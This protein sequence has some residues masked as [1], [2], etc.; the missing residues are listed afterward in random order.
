LD[1]INEPIAF[2]TDTNDVAL[3]SL[4]WADIFGCHITSVWLRRLTLQRQATVACRL[5][6]LSEDE[7]LSGCDLGFL[8]AGGVE[9]VVP[10]VV[11]SV[12]LDRSAIREKVGRLNRS[13]R[14][15]ARPRDRIPKLASTLQRVYSTGRKRVAQP[16]MNTE[17]SVEAGGTPSSELVHLGLTPNRTRARNGACL[18]AVAIKQQDPFPRCEVGS[19]HLIPNP[20]YRQRFFQA[21]PGTYAR[22][23]AGHL[24]G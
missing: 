12:S 6:A 3:P 7:M 14:A 2:R 21:L 19:V 23:F 17:Q 5:R 1:F 13:I 9:I 16:R 24:L 15:K 8:G 20:R 22:S 18:E 10:V 4:C 11:V